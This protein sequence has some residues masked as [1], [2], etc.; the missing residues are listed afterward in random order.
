[1][2]FFALICVRPT[3]FRSSSVRADVVHGGA[4]V[5]HVCRLAAVSAEGVA[6]AQGRLWAVAFPRAEVL[7]GEGG[8]VTPLI[9]WRPRGHGPRCRRCPIGRPI[10]RYSGSLPRKKER[11]KR[12]TT[13]HLIA[14]HPRRRLKM[15]VCEGRPHSIAPDSLGRAE[16]RGPL[17]DFSA[18]FADSGASASYYC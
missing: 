7:M 16:Y 15:G 11:C 13:T 12:P 10:P 18:K 6:G 9:C 1:M 17:V 3:V 14:S 4:R 2:S 8:G 5:R